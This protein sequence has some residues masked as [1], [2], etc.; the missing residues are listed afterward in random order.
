MCEALL[1]RGHRVYALDNL[2]TGQRKNIEH[3]LHNP[4]FTWIEEDIRSSVYMN[5]GCDYI[6]NLASPASPIDF[7]RIPDFILTTSSQGGL[8][9]LRWAQINKARYLYASTSEIYGDPLEHPQKE[10]YF[11]NVNTIGVRGCYDEAKRFGEALA[12][13]FHREHKVDVRIARIFNTYG[14]RMRLEDG[15]VI[16]NFFNQAFSK[17]PMTIFGDGSQ[18]RSLCYVTDL[19]EGLI[20]LMESDVES[21]V[22][23]GNPRETTI[24]EIGQ[25]VAKVCETQAKFEFFEGRENDPKQ[26]RPDITKAKELLKWEPTVSLEKGLLSTRD[27]FS[28][29]FEK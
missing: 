16:P 4:N 29:H 19:V 18:T 24:L 27:Y 13:A 6:Y 5:V 23:L 9:L 3:L 21:P 25:T 10:T 22:N 1:A 15:R 2:V 17:K 20:R 28:K 26:R 12:M 8:N 7:D 14:P 11:G